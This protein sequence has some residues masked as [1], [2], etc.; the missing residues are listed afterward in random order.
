[1]SRLATPLRL[2]LVGWALLSAAWVVGNPPFGGPDEGQHYLRALQVGRGH[3]ITTARPGAA[4]G[5]TE[6]Q[7]AWTRQGTYTMHVPAG[8]AP[9]DYECWTSD[10]RS[11]AGCLDAFRPPERGFTTVAAVGNYQ[12]LPYL[13]PGL[14][15][16]AASAPG[17]ALR[18]ARAAGAL[19][20]LALLW[21]ALRMTWS[22]AAGALSLLGLL[23]AVTP[24]VIFCASV[25]TGSG[26]EIAAGIAFAASLL[27]LRRD[28][29][30]ARSPWVW[31]GVGAS[32][33]VLVLS[34][35]TGPVYLLLIALPVLALGGGG[36]A[37]R[38][39][40]GRAGAAV[41]AVATILAAVVGNRVW[42]RAHGPHPVT[43]FS[44]VR[45]VLGDAVSEWWR[46][47]SE[48]I[49]KFGYLEYRLPPVAYVLWFA[50]GFA[51]I[52]AALRVARGRERRVLAAT[53]LAATLL[54]ML[55]WIYAIRQTGFGL[56]GR[57]VLP[58]LAVVPLMAGEL[59]R[60]H[61]AALGERLRR[62]LVIA[63]PA[64]VGLVHLL[65]FYWAARRAAVGTDGPLVFIGDSAWSPPLGWGPWLALAL[66][67]SVALAIA[68]ARDRV[69]QV[70]SGKSA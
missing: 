29:S 54:P 39:L 48:L 42:E 12:P 27:R 62:R 17:P 36:A 67:G 25:L 46:A 3:L 21:V 11:N 64:C 69:S 7:I 22:P 49:G 5:E 55:L 10:R 2:V 4:V 28:E 33:A 32:G 58:V 15:T 30:C 45:A 43:G 19:L 9:H 6:R 57:H 24:M 34:R 40:R 8:M 61:A 37:W 52:A 51:L 50:A 16:R 68:L 53:V 26:P 35:T 38:H 63:I 1:V 44:N 18:L 23:L 70:S 14:A 56:Q 66:A 31:A 41:A 59:I 13:L 20:S 65:A 47:S 60:E